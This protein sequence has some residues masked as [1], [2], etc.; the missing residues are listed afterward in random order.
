M[1]KTIPP[2]IQASA[3]TLAMT[4]ASAA[5]AAPSGTVAFLMPD[6]AS[7]RYEQ[8]DY[9]GFK[10]EMSKLCP[11]CKVLYQNA[12]GNLSQQQQQF[13]S[14][15]SQGAKVI[16]IDP[17][18]STA[19][20][21]LVK[22]AQ[23]QGVKVIAYDRPI[24]STPADYYV[25]FDNTGI[26]KAIAESLVKHMKEMNIPTDKGGSAAGQRIADRCRGRAHQGRHPPGHQG[27]RL[28]DTGR[29]RH[30][31]LGAAESAAVGE[32]ADH[33]FRAR[34]RRRRGRQRRHGRRHHRG[35]QGGRPE[36]GAAGQRQ[37]R[38]D[39]GA[40]AHHRGAISTTR[41]PSRARSSRRPLPRSRSASCR[42]RNPKPR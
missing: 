31:R 5:F 19:A 13:N 1:N 2:L 11:D 8:H 23:G 10:A 15:L 6:Q 9:P 25:S 20:A 12:N 32:R 14:M 21:S 28:Q 30:A 42:V 36:P 39:R 38:D 41:S 33:A 3:L 7:T 29:V 26:G 27:Q 16:V 34:D 24:P 40:A 35:V 37:R 17:V 4:A 18:D 22:M